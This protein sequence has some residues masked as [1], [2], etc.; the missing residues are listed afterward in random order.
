MYILNGVP[1]V[2][3]TDNQQQWN[4]LYV[5]F[6]KLLDNF[7]ATGELPFYSWTRF[8]GNNFYAS[9]SIYTIGDIY[10]WIGYIFKNFHY[11]DIAAIL[12]YLK[13]IVSGISMY[14]CL[15]QFKYK[16]NTKILG[17]LLFAL[18]SYAVFFTTQPLFLS[19]YSL[20]PLMFA[21]IEIYFKNKKPYLFIIVTAML[22]LNN[23]YMFYSLAI[24]MVIYFTYRYY[25]IHEDFKGFFKSAI[26]LIGY[27]FIG[28][29]ITGFM[30]VPVVYFILDNSRVGVNAGNLLFFD[31]INI[32]MHLFVSFFSPSYTHIMLYDNSLFSGVY[33]TGEINIWAG[34]LVSL[35]LPQLFFIKNK[36]KKN[37]NLILYSCLIV[38]LFIPFFDSMMHGFSE[39]SFRWSCFIIF[40]NIL[41]VMEILD[42]HES[43]NFRIL[44]VSSIILIATLIIYIPLL[45]L[46]SGGADLVFTKYFEQFLVFLLTAI[47]IGILCFAIKKLTIS[48]LI[49]I[50]CIELLLFGS[51]FYYDQMKMSKAIDYDFLYKSTHILETEEGEFNTFIQ[52]IE[53]SNSLEF[54]RIF[55]DKNSIYWN[56]SLNMSSYYDIKGTMTYDSTYQNSHNQMKKLTEGGN[57]F[58]MMS[59]EDYQLLTLLNVKYAIVSNPNQ[60]PIGGEWR[61]I[62]DSYRG[63]LHIYRNDRYRSLGT[64]YSRV[65]STD[66]YLAINDTNEF[67]KSVIAEPE[68][69]G[70]IEEYVTED[71]S[72]LENIRY[73]GNHLFATYNSNEKGFMVIGIPFDEGWDITINGEI[74]DKYMVNGGLIGIPIPEGECSL[75]MYFTPAGF[76]LGAI[77]S[78]M[79]IILFG[80]VVYLGR[81]R[82]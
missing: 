7:F 62:T 65:I 6:Y 50:S 66:D 76:K 44:K 30:I 4:L 52:N 80:F 14:F 23:F 81:K 36:V 69:V 57:D 28:V 3:G 5:E 18:S 78:A 53:P 46:L 21:S 29:M 25:I 33:S 56:Y 75:E 67:L 9:K 63:T 42:N 51:L 54:Y 74:V 38:M 49:L 59:I 12:N 34:S 60:L 48:K 24:F 2:L 1:I 79:G 41:L 68:D 73:S 58:W 16:E 31:K 10:V 71:F 22:L 27:C 8:L 37:A 55:V 11:F 64:T 47:F 17:S 43:I 77:I 15:S 35:L 70:K 82:K 72:Q 13:L 26:I 61:L 20:F 32:Y 39:P 45:S 40:M 19:F